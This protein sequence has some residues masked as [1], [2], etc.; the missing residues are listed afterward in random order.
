MAQ[1]GAPSVAMQSLMSTAPL[2][3]SPISTPRPL[4][5]ASSHPSATSHTSSLAPHSAAAP[6]KRAYLPPGMTAIQTAMRQPGASISDSSSAPAGGGRQGAFGSSEATDPSPPC[7]AAPYAPSLLTTPSLIASHTIHTSASVI[8]S[9]TVH[10][11]HRTSV[12]QRR[13]LQMSPPMTDS[14]L[15]QRYSSGLDPKPHALTTA[16]LYPPSEEGSSAPDVAMERRAE[17]LMFVPPA[18]PESHAPPLSSAPPDLA[19]ERRA[20]QLMELI[21]PDSELDLAA[22]LA[23]L[24]AKGGDMDMAYETILEMTAAADPMSAPSC[25]SGDGGGENGRGAGRG[26]GASYSELQDPNMD[27]GGCSLPLSPRPSPSDLD[28]DPDPA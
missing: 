1:A 5:V 18:V 24:Q 3:R 28:L 27:A 9:H 15:S 26:G 23:V 16:D 10:T 21:G 12:M 6:V 20:E 25:W 7:S 22:C 13:A 17:Q 4:Y 11:S 2:L 14:G 19:M 8:A